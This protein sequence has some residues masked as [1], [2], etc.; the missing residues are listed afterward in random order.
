MPNQKTDAEAALQKLGQRVRA[1][2]SKQH[3]VSDRS[4]E[5]VKNTVREQW[6]QEQVAEPK[7]KPSPSRTREPQRKPPEP[8]QER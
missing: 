5:T 7:K 1:G 4:I 2:W 3:P 8:E 6:E